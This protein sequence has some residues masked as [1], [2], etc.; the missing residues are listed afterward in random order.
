MKFLNKKYKFSKDWPFRLWWNKW[1]KCSSVNANK[2][3]NLCKCV[4]H[5]L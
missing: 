3:P 5:I 2:N 1:S 4:S